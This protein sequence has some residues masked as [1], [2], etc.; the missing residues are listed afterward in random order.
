VIAAQRAPS[1]RAPL[2]AAAAGKTPTASASR[3]RPSLSFSSW[4]FLVSGEDAS[5]YTPV[6]PLVELTV[7]ARRPL[8]PV[9]SNAGC[10]FASRR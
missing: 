2:V 10:Q 6:I 1:S 7:I 8:S 5:L 9:S 4:A 3:S